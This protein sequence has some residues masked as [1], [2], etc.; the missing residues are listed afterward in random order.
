MQ[1]HNNFPLYYFWTSFHFF[2]RSSMNPNRKGMYETF[3]L[4]PSKK[5]ATLTLLEPREREH[6]WLA[7]VSFPPRNEVS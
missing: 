4:H 6:Q 3:S 1:K 5:K 7:E 2:P